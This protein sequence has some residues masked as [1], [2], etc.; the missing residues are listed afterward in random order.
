MVI[1]MVFLVA[2]SSS[3][4]VSGS[5]CLN[6]STLLGGGEEGDGEY[7]PVLLVGRYRMIVDST[8]QQVSSYLVHRCIFLY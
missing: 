7:A 6:D 4:L 1:A 5:I 3:L 2:A 8:N